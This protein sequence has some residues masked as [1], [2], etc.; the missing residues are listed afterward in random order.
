VPSRRGGREASSRSPQV[1]PASV[2]VASRVAVKVGVASYQ[3][4]MNVAM[5]LKGVGTDWLAPCADWGSLSL[6]LGS[7]LFFLSGLFVCVG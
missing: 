6:L 2:H 1:A 7:V 3:Q 4:L 5:E